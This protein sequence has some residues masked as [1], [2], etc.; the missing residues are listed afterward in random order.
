MSFYP[1]WLS[2]W[3]ELEPE[4]RLAVSIAVFKKK[5]LPIICP[6]AKSVYGIHHPKGLS[7]LAQLRADL[8]KLN[9]RKVKYNF[10]N[11]I[12]PM[13]PTSDGV[14]DTE[15]F[16][17]LCH[18]FNVQQQDPLAGIVELLWPYVLLTYLSDD[19]LTQ[20]LVYGI[21]E[22][23]FDLNKNTFKFTLCFIHEAGC[24]D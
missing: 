20:L 13:C 12:N 5:I 14:E 9:F 15:H 2:E 6:P 18:S 16:L 21:Q 23:S 22:L 19:A 8:S 11:T 4:L 10:L 7:Y 17:L 24:F 1:S 3:N